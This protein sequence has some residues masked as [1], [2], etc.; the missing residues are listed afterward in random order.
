MPIRS[1]EA[2]AF[3][4]SGGPGLMIYNESEEAV[5]RDWL[6]AGRYDVVIADAEPPHSWKYRL[7]GS[8]RG[9]GLCHPNLHTPCE[10]ASGVDLRWENIGRKSVDCSPILGLQ[11]CIFRGKV[12][13]KSLGFLSHCCSKFPGA[14]KIPP[15]LRNP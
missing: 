12:W 9:P 10:K 13:A 5:F 7:P 8:L 6:E 3:A 1:L 11:G 15:R 4:A 14:S 2:A